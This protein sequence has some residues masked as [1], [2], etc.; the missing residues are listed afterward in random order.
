[1]VFTNRIQVHTKGFSDI[2]DLSVQASNMLDQSKVKEGMIHLF[3]VGSTASLTTMEFEPALVRDVKEALE[4]LFPSDAVSHHSQ[5]WGDDNG[6]SHL[7]ATMMGPSLCVPVENGS[8]SLGTWQQIVLI[9]HDNRA[10]NREVIIQ[11]IGDPQ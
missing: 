7:R 9:D 10:R 3:V 6:F 4:R 11:V 1:M 2:I 5:T 8:M